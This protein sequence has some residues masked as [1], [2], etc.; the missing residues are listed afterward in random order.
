MNNLQLNIVRHKAN[1]Y[2]M[3]EGDHNSSLF[4]IIQEGVVKINDTVSKLLGYGEQTLQKGDFFGVVSSMSKFP[5]IETAFS[6]TDTLL[7]AIKNDQFPLLL[8]KSPNIALKIIKKFS[9]DLRHYDE[10]IAKSN[11]KSSGMV[12][13][14]E[15]DVL[16]NNGNYYL[17]KNNYNFAYRIFSNYNLSYPEGK[18]KKQANEKIN[19]VKPYINPLYTE[20]KLQGLNAIVPENFLIFSE[21]EIGDKLYI[22]QKGKIK[23]TKIINNSEILIAVLKDGD[24][25]GEMALLED[26]PRTANAITSEKTNLLVVDRKNF[27]FMVINQPAMATKLIELLSERIWVAYRQIQ[28]TFINDPMGKL[29]DMLLI[30]LLKNRVQIIPKGQFQ[31]PFGI[32]DLIKMV[33]LSEADLTKYYN[34][35]IGTKK[36][37]EINGNLFIK[38]VSIVEKQ[39]EYYKKILEIQSKI[40]KN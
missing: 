18:Y 7:I 13:V 40:K 15:E 38:D 21:G 29:W 28:N 10:Y 37:E 36:I 1:S 30:Q 23:I 20:L 22:I 34:E 12:N 33:G 31:C 2:I 8:Q 27:N 3:I 14:N 24:I 25:F 19:L 35:L 17:S 4:Y 16:F 39:A 11:I 32:K 5:R 9:T 26:K 6:Q